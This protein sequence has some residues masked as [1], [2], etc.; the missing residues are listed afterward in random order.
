VNRVHLLEVGKLYN[1]DRT[2]WPE[3]N[4]YNFRAGQ[5]EL[6][7]FYERPTAEEVEAFSKGETEF[8]MHFERGVIFFLYKFGDLAWADATYSWHLV[9]EDER[10]LPSPP[11]S[12]E[13]RTL[14]SVL[15]VDASTGILKSMRALTLSPRFTRELGRAIR[16]QAAASFST[17]SHDAALSI[18]YGKYSTTNQLLKAALVRTKGGA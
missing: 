13:E 8:A 3:T 17:Q 9:P 12:A 2:S 11:A 1:P 7:I 10:Q 6:V 18:L 16:E 4:Q 15:L 5:H 14:L